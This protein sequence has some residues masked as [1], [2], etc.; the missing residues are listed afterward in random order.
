LG[1]RPT[2]AGLGREPG[3]AGIAAGRP[4]VVFFA[5]MFLY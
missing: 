5:M 4:G 1:A 3:V 2:G